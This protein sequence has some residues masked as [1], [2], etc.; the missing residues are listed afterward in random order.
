MKVLEQQTHCRIRQCFVPGS[1]SRSK[2][3]HWLSRTAVSNQLGREPAGALP[4]AY[5]YLRTDGQHKLVS[6]YFKLGGIFVPSFL[7]ARAY[8]YTPGSRVSPVAPRRLARTK[9]FYARNLG[10]SR[11]AAVLECNYPDPVSN[12]GASPTMLVPPRFML[13]TLLDWID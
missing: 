12:V 2:L 10:A 3:G 4:S 8:A 13:T 7:W 11:K 1:S 6:C 5:F 9:S